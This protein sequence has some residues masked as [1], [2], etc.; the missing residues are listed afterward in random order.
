MSFPSYSCFPSTSEWLLEEAE[1][2][3]LQ[4]RGG[5]VL[6]FSQGRRPEAS[7]TV[8]CPSEE[9]NKQFWE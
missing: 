7:S 9:N 8:R 5:L 2:I 3:L 1:G 4:I 6:N